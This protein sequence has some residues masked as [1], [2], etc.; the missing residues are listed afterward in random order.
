MHKL[1]THE[2]LNISISVAVP[3]SSQHCQAESH[4]SLQGQDGYISNNYDALTAGTPDTCPWILEA[5]PGQHIN[6]T[7]ITFL[8]HTQP[9]HT[10]SYGYVDYNLHSS[11]SILSQITK[12]I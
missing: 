1:Q 11:N 3:K 8:H 4:M 9:V 5:D 6:I 2:Q 12:V 10:N 7:L